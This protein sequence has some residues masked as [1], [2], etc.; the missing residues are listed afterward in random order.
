MIGICPKC[1]NYD[2]DKEVSCCVIKCPK[3]AHTWKFKKLPLFILT[4]CSGVG[5]TTTGQ[6]LLQRNIGFVVLDSD[7]LPGKDYDSWAEQMQ[8][9]SKNIMQSGIPVLWTMTGALERHGS[10]YNRRFFSE[11]YF[12]ALVCDENE[13]RRKLT[14]GRGVSDK[15][16]IESS[17]EYNEYFKTHT[18]IGDIGFDTYDI[19]GKSVSEVADYVEKWVNSKLNN[20]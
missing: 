4:G 6:E 14:E 12:L 20:E 9:L 11:I 18:S 3:C 10:T 16:W 1:G 8:N 15:D 2:W 19:T 17:V 5:K 13:L 7:I